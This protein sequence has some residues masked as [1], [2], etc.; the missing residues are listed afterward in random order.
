MQKPFDG[1][2]NNTELQK[3]NFSQN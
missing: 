1:K 2:S 3:M